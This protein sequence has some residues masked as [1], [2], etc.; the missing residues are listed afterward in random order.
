MFLATKAVSR[1]TDV[2]TKH[3]NAKKALIPANKAEGYKHARKKYACGT[4]HGD[5]DWPR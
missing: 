2:K 1:F 3:E 5:E 4:I